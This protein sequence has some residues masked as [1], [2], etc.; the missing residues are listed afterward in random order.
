MN[1]L[2][3]LGFIWVIVGFAVGLFCRSLFKDRLR[4]A[5][6]LISL[7]PWLVYLLITIAT[8]ASSIEQNQL[9]I[10]VGASLAIGI[11][12][13]WVGLR[14]HSRQGSSLIWLPALLAVLQLFLA[15]NWLSSILG[16]SLD[17]TYVPTLLYLAATLSVCFMLIAYRMPLPKFNLL[18]RKSRKKEPAK[19]ARKKQSKTP[20]TAQKNPRKP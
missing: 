14:S 18:K 19:K 13:L 1:I 17:F 12:I 10:F 5:P 3:R 2:T 4:V 16:Y 11:L 6:F 9:M 7:L 8:F 20:K 15:T